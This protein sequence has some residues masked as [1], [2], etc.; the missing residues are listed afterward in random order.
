M[1]YLLYPLAGALAISKEMLLAG[2]ILPVMA[3]VWWAVRR[4]RKKLD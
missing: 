3:G 4:V 2:T 1:G